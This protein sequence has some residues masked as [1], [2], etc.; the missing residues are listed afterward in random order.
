MYEVFYAY[1]KL[2]IVK[3]SPLYHYLDLKLLTISMLIVFLFI[4][5]VFGVCLRVSLL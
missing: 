1:G 5:R 4:Y 2:E 3:N